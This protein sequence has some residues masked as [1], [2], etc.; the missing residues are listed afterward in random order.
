M[1]PAHSNT[2]D[3]AVVSAYLAQKYPKAVRLILG[4]SQVR[5]TTCSSVPLATPC[6]SA[7]GP[8]APLFSSTSRRLLRPLGY[9]PLSHL[10]PLPPKTYNSK[11]NSWMP[12]GP[13]LPRLTRGLQGVYKKRPAVK[14][15]DCSPAPLA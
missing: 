15:R 13:S 7:P 3:L 4:F 8:H 10:A 2:D 9:A 1:F 6:T 12:S 14:K 5:T 11:V